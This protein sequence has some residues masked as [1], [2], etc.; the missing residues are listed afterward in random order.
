MSIQALQSRLNKLNEAIQ[1]IESS[2][3]S[4]SRDEDANLNIRFRNDKLYKFPVIPFRLYQIEAQKKLFQEGINRFLLVR[5]RR[6]GKEVE[7][8]S[9]LIQGAL[10]KPGLYLMIY[11]TNVRARM[12]LWDGAIVMPDGSSFKFLDMIPPAFLKS[13]PKKDEMKIELINGSIIKVLGS[14]IDPDKLRGT[15]ARGIVISEFAFG[16]PRVMHILMPA[17]RQNNGWLICQTTFNGMNHAYKLWKNNKD[18]PK[19]YCRVDSVENLVDENGYRYI[20]DEMIEEDRQAGMP[21]YLIQQEYYSVVQVNQETMYFAVQI[22]FLYAN[23]RI[24]SD[25][26]LPNRPVYTFWDIGR[27]DTNAVLLVQF[28]DRMFPHIIGYMENR[29]KTPDFYVD[30]ARRMAARLGLHV[31]AHFIPHDGEKRDY[32]TGQN[33]VDFGQQIGEVFYIVP[34][35]IKKINAIQQMRKMIYK[36]KFNKEKTDRIIDCLS[37]YQKEYD[38]KNDIYKD[39]PLHNWASHGVDAFQTMTLAVDANMINTNSTDVIYINN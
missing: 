26:W 15:N 6:S 25:L 19:W 37:N 22:E 39:A 23:D 12:V 1:G 14:D 7:S 2:K 17:L 31:K 29:N 20:T 9:F 33:T 34:R 4:H 21:E 11:P 30:E 8:W 24:I 38:E 10:E 18:N 28:D 3:F 36:C 27:N 16:D 32:N 5:P 35:P 13:R